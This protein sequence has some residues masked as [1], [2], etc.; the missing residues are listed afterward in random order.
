MYIPICGCIHQGYNE[1]KFFSGAFF[2]SPK[3][4]AENR[5]RKSKCQN[6][7]LGFQIHTSAPTLV[8]IHFILFNFPWA[9]CFCLNRHLFYESV[10]MCVCLIDFPNPLT[11]YEHVFPEIGIQWGGKK[12]FIHSSTRLCR[13]LK[14]ISC[15]FGGGGAEEC[16]RENGK[17]ML[18]CCDS[19][20][21]PVVAVGRPGRR[22]RER[23]RE[24]EIERGRERE[25]DEL[26]AGGI[27]DR[28]KDC[29]LLGLRE[30]E[31]TGCFDVLICV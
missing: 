3:I 24:E 29:W 31:C 2:E 16:F 14:T 13:T 22:N 10:C 15:W 9:F 18:C 20:L 28:D 7:I 6:V 27:L 12:L 11:F 25:R 21:L 5:K 19:R 4:E 1:N 26:L 17:E 30:N 23:E 8:E